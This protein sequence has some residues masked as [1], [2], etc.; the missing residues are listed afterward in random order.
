VAAWI[1]WVDDFDGSGV[2]GVWVPVAYLRSDAADAYHDSTG[3]FSWIELVGSE[4]C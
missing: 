1:V 4:V 2:E 3:M